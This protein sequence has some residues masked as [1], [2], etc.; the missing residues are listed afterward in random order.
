MQ[1]AMGQQVNTTT[2][3]GVP[4][5][6]ILRN[7][8]CQLLIV[9]ITNFLTSFTAIF[10]ECSKPGVSWGYMEQELNLVFIMELR[11][12]ASNLCPAYC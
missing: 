9:T 4:F 3:G 7:R 2:L 6:I 11:L 5:D 1:Y 12:G 10:G 8:D